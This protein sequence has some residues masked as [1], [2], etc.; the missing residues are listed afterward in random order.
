[1][2]LPGG[3]TLSLDQA[4]PVTEG[5]CNAQAVNP[6]I[7]RCTTDD[8]RTV[9]VKLRRGPDDPRRRDGFRR[10]LTA[11]LRLAELGCDAGPRLLATDDSAGLL[12]LEDLGDGPALEDLLVGDDPAAATTGFVALARAV[13]G[14]H[15]ATL[16]QADDIGTFVFDVAEHWRRI[17]AFAATGDAGR[18]LAAVREVLDSGPRA[19]SNGDLAPQN[20]RLAAGRIRLL[21]FEDAAGQHPLLDVAHFRLPFYGGPCWARIPPA[22]TARAEAAYRAATGRDDDR[23]Y[24]E[25]LAAAVAAWTVI[26][27]VR[28]PALLAADPPHPMGFSRRGQLL[29]T[30][31]VGADATAGIFPRLSAWFGGTGRRLRER[32]P[33]LP[34]SQAMYPAYREVASLPMCQ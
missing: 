15:A 21:D 31:L 24:A 23:A 18:D 5:W 7:L 22:V 32:W 2:D 8:G 16:G 29:D 12:V 25:G 9:I 33:G 10:E 14:M 13:G 34:E 20:C 4:R 28:L 1:V 11:L 19:L 3:V 17:G 27:F 6:R 30:L 26:R